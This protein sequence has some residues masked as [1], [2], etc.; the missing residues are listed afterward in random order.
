M[1]NKNTP[2][3]PAV[4]GV[5]ICA[6]VISVA[7]LLWLLLIDSKSVGVCIGIITGSV[8]YFIYIFPNLTVIVPPNKGWLISNSFKSESSERDPG[9][10]G[11]RKIQ[12]QRELQAGFH[13]VY[14]WESMSPPEVDM[15]KKFFVKKDDE[16]PYT[17]KDG[18][19]LDLKYVIQIVPLPGYLTNFV[20]TTEADIQTRVKARVESWL[21]GKIGELEKPRF[22]KAFIDSLKE[23]FKSVYSGKNLHDDEIGM[24]IWTGIPEI[25]D[26]DLPKEV[27]KARNEKE[28]LMI[29]IEAAQDIMMRSGG[30]I[31]LKT[32][33]NAIYRLR[34][35]SSGN[36]NIIDFNPFG[37]E[38]GGKKGKKKEGE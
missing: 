13:W 7:I 17:L 34:A 29:D 23:D 38:S 16:E 24:G 31:D 6:I 35:A 22:D 3:G 27:Q 19:L 20:R 5:T 37:N 33:L 1:K 21:Q 14:P 32:A 9:F 11:Y 10:D 30:K 18:S 8:I 26:V 12:A 28:T 4:L 25:T 15:Q 36:A 2:N